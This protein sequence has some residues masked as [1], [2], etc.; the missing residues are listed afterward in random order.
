MPAASASP[1]PTVT[2]QRPCRDHHEGTVRSTSPSNVD[3]S[4]VRSA[5]RR[6]MRRGIDQVVVIVDRHR[7]VNQVETQPGDPG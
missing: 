1:D 4:P 5:I 6:M 7:A 3:C 2:T